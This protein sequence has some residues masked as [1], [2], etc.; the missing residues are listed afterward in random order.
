MRAALIAPAIFLF[1]EL[2]NVIAMYVVPGSKQA[3]A[4]GVFSAWEKSKADPELHAFVRYL[5]Y[6]VAGTKVIFIALLSTILVFGDARLQAVALLAMVASI[7]TFYWK[8]FPLIRKMDRAGQITPKHYS[9][10]LG[11]MIAGFM[12]ALGVSAWML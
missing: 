7:A 6:W 11:V 2:T 8:L 9:A 10:M 3:N 12:L 1:L 5:V 4:V